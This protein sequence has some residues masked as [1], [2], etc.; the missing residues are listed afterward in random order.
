MRSSPRRERNGSTRSDLRR[1]VDWMCGSCAG[2]ADGAGDAGC[3]GGSCA[4]AADGAGDAGCVG[5]SRAGAADGA[6]DA[7]CARRPGG[8]A[9]TS[10]TSNEMNRHTWLERFTSSL[11]ARPSAGPPCLH[12]TSRARRTS[13]RSRSG[14]R[15]PSTREVERGTRGTTQGHEQGGVGRERTGAD[16]AQRCTRR[17]SR[18]QF[19]RRGRVS[20]TPRLTRSVVAAREKRR[21]FQG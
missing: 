8:H 17:S 1:G 3:V 21:P 12:S 11:H 4:G 7:G 10:R 2:A 15:A 19:Q 14:R 6:G 5:G 13:W 18:G 16:G 9:A 20:A